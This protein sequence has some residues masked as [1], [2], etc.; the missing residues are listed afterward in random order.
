MSTGPSRIEIERDDPEATLLGRGQRL[1]ETRKGYQ[2][3]VDQIF[4]VS[5]LGSSRGEWAREP[6][7]DSLV[8]GCE[9]ETV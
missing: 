6:R 4:S 7:P 5:C 8:R 9:S 1:P 2:S 3:T